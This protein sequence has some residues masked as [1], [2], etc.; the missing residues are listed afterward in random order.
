MSYNEPLNQSVCWNS[1]FSSEIVLMKDILYFC[2]VDTQEEAIK[3]L[4]SAKERIE[5]EKYKLGKLYQ[6]IYSSF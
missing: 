3:T 2:E 5:R 1:L 4:T 6:A